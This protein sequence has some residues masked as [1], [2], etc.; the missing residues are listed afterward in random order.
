M[1]TNRVSSV[2][3]L[4]GIVMVVM[5]LDHVRDYVH[6]DASLHNPSDPL[7]TTIL[8]YFTRWIT[9]FCAPVFS[10]LAGIS[11]YLVGLRKSKSELSAFL[12]KRGLWLIFLELT[13]VNFGWY[14]DPEFRN[15]NLLV[16]WALG[17]SMITLALLIHLS[18]RNILL[19]SC[20]VILGHNAL[21]G[22]HFQGS[23][24]WSILHDPAIFQIMPGFL[25]DIE[26]TL[27]PW[28]TVMSLGYCF[29]ALFDPEVDRALRMRVLR[30]SGIIMIITFFVIRGINIYGDPRPWTEYETLVQ[31]AMSFFN[32]A[33]YPPSL[34]YLLMTLGPAMLI[35]AYTENAR[36][37]VVEFFSTFGRV[38]FF[39][40]LL[41]VY[42][43]HV[44]ALILAGLF[45]FGWRVMILKRWVT[46]NPDLQGY[47]FNLWVVYLVWVITI[48]ILYPLCKWYDV[49]K[50]GNRAKWW[51]SYL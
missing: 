51:L 10:F 1:H 3:L 44:L 46:D 30:N 27:I 26:Y 2:D 28:V 40:Y 11:V 18:V 14:F 33:K 23:Y 4:K 39:Y 49:Y 21:D 19:I 42:L 50:K 41:H 20:A 34:V 43:I 35:L 31:T 32:A 38:P 9:H 24:A 48:A 15:P 45:G 29:G 16:I 22:I 37:R 17:A 47:G 6:I 8:L 12:I 25:L 7:N 36:G 5:A 13:I